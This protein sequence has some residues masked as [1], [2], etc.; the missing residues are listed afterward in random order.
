MV[1]DGAP[2]LGASGVDGLWMNVGHGSTG[3]AMSMGSGR[4]VADLVTRHAPEIDL[5]GL[6]LARYRR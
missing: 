3:W 5:D 4:V 1:P 2:L 6:T